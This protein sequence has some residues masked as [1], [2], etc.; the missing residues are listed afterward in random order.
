M[1]RPL[2]AGRRRRGFAAV[3]VVAG[4]AAIVLA[5]AAIAGGALR[6]SGRM[7]TA[8]RTEAELRRS[9]EGLLAGALAGIAREG[10][11]WRPPPPRGP[12]PATLAVS[13]AG[14][15]RLA[16]RAT[17]RRGRDRAALSLLVL[18]D[19]AAEAGKRVLDAW[20]AP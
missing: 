10:S 11:A 5:A 8:R 3:A 9:A 16:V 1:R 6:A 18:C 19:D 14:E 15:K 2:L 7:A 13:P 12:D 4:L 20:E 17:A